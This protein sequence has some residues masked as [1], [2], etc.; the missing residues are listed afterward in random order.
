MKPGW[1]RAG[2][3][4]GEDRARTGRGTGERKGEDGGVQGCERARE[5]N[6]PLHYTNQ[7]PG[8]FYYVYVMEQNTLHKEIPRIFFMYVIILVLQ[9]IILAPWYAGGA[10]LP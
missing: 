7:F 2:R 1:T 3:G 9:V 4:P 10:L 8:E 5:E 6:A